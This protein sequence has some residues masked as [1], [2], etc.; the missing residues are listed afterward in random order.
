MRR[1]LHAYYLLTS[2]DPTPEKKLL[3]ALEAFLRPLK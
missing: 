2:Y 3:D 1:I